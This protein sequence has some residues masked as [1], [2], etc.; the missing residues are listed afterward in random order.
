MKVWLHITL[1]ALG[2]VVSAGTMMTNVVPPKY[3][4]LVVAVVSFAQALLAWYN[5]YFN[6]DGTPSTVAYIA[7]K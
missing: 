4:P 6:P 1:Q 5:H 3:Q 7:K 2:F